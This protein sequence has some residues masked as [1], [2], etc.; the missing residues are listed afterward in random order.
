MTDAVAVIA[1]G[2]VQQLIHSFDEIPFGK[3]AVIGLVDADSG[4]GLDFPVDVPHLKGRAAEL[5][6]QPP[7]KPNSLLEIGGGQDD[8]EFV[9]AEAA[10]RVETTNRALDEPGK[11]TKHRIADFMAVAVVHGLEL[12]EVHQDQAGGLA[13]APGAF[14]FETEGVIEMAQVRQAGEFVGMDEGAQ[15]FHLPAQ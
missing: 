11:M 14:E 4:A 2:K 9:S 10:G 5:G 8:G 12:V 3:F 6:L 15:V 7:G 13:A 1:F